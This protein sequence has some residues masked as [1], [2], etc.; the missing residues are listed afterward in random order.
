MKTATRAT[1]S[2]ITTDSAISGAAKAAAGRKT[3]RDVAAVD[4]LVGVADGDRFRRST[5]R[6]GWARAVGWRSASP[7]RPSWPHCHGADPG[8]SACRPGK[9]NHERRENHRARPD[10]LLKAEKRWL[11]I[12]PDQ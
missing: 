4:V 7:F 2:R 12:D 5:S 10:S 1:R 3:T 8:C 9:E 6:S 11:G